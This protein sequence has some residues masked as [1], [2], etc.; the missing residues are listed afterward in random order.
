MFYCCMSLG[1]DSIL[2]FP[3][4][5]D[6][7]HSHKPTSCFNSQK[8]W[9]SINIKVYRTKLHYL[10][11]VYNLTLWVGFVGAC[12]M[13]FVFF[14]HPLHN[15]TL[16]ISSMLLNG[17]CK[18]LNGTIAHYKEKIEPT[19]RGPKWLQC[20]NH[21]ILAKQHTTWNVHIIGK[22]DYMSIFDMHGR[23]GWLLVISHPF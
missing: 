8:D 23:Q 20:C 17:H 3:L 16:V 11:V 14:F 7:R 13:F 15:W 5:V 10:F 9:T 2:D 6:L 22:D 18:P 19:P 12:Y 1:F 4:Q 21:D